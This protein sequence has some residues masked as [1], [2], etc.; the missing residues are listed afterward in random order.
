MRKIVSNVANGHSVI[1]RERGVEG[2]LRA[3]AQRSY[4]RFVNLE[5]SW[6]AKK[7]IFGYDEQICPGIFRFSLPFVTNLSRNIVHEQPRCARPRRTSSRRSRRR[8]TKKG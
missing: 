7:E 2:L 5:E 8:R 1:S 3:A 4:L 6:S